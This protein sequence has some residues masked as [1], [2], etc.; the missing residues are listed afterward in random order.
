MFKVYKL[1]CY[2]LGNAAQEHLLPFLPEI[3]EHIQNCL[4]TLNGKDDDGEL[5]ILHTQALG[6]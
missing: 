1:L 3:L 4:S 2:R 6:K 5:C